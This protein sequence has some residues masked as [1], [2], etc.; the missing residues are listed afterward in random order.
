M[1]WGQPVYEATIVRA[2]ERGR[3][4]GRLTRGLIWAAL[5]IFVISIFAFLLGLAPTPPPIY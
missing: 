4:L 2:R 5:A 3:P 1:N